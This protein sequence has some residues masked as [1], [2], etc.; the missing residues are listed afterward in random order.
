HREAVGYR[1]AAQ[2]RSGEIVVAPIIGAPVGFPPR[3][4]VL[5]IVRRCQCSATVAW[6]C[7]RV[8]IREACHEYA[9]LAMV[10]W[11]FAGLRAKRASPIGRNPRSPDLDR[12]RQ[13]LYESR[14]PEQQRAA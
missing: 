3:R 6:D 11:H 2:H 12:I 13:R 9:C 8:A 4:F 5:I 1:T 14:L 7:T 10:P